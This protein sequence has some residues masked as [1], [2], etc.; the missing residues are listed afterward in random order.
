MAHFVVPLFLASVLVVVFKP[1]HSRVVYQF[2]GYPRVSA[3]ITTLLI[4]LVVLLPTVWLGWK[5]AI[6]LRDVYATLNPPETASNVQ[7]LGAA[8]D[9]SAAREEPGGR[10]A[11]ATTPPV[12]LETDDAAIVVSADPDAL[13]PEVAKLLQNIADRAPLA[14]K[15]AY[16]A[17]FKKDFDGNS[18]APLYWRARGLLGSIAVTGAQTVLKFVF[19]LAIMVLAL[20]YFLAD[21]PRMLANLMKMSPLDDEYERE[22]LDK[23]ASVSRAVVVASLASAVAQ[24]LLAGIGYYF[25]LNPGAPIF[26]LT[27]V[28][29]VLAIVPF[30]GAAAVWIPTAIYI[31]LY[32][33]IDG[34]I[35][36]GDTFTAIML[37]IYGT[38]V[39]SAID[40]VIKPLV[41]HGQ[42]NL[43]PLVALISILG[44]VQ[45]L[46][47]IGILVGPMLVAFIQALLNMV[48]KELVRL[49]DGTLQEKHGARAAVLP[50]GEATELE[51]EAA[52]KGR[53]GLVDKLISTPPIAAG[54]KAQAAPS[55]GGSPR[56][57]VKRRRKR[58]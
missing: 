14:I 40:N 3:L 21:G 26:L 35:I 1:L 27:M 24:G 58:R 41:L 13:S 45:T 33:E 15:N 30:A 5:A 17:V 19:G 50:L 16:H 8:P 34:Q 25:A 28:S 37:A 10:D 44:G 36:P 54:P 52:V 20:Y 4:M 11:A 22:L 46:G 53:G 43:H 49:G 47:P 2:P 56:P 6:E 31:A 23:F 12:I 9:V 38:C 32:Q 18:L 51:A 55:T 29:M 48:N 39:V 57:A 42:S 7:E